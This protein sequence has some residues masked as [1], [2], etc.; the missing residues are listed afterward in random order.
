M[1]PANDKA[2]PSGRLEAEAGYGL[3]GP[4]RV[5]G[6]VTPYAGCG[7]AGEDARTW[8]LGVRWTLGSDVTLG[9]E[10]TR[11]ETADD[12]EHG[13][14]FRIAIRWRRRGIRRRDFGIDRNGRP[15][16]RAPQQ[17]RAK[18][19]FHRDQ[20]STPPPGSNAAL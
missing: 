4:A 17:R 13:V 7:L 1:A 19:E 6:T 18:V 5:E 14:M 10:G 8:H 11:R 12:D 3:A 9:L 2:D 15:Q 20:T 16:T